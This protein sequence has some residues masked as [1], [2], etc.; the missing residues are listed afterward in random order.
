MLA[1]ATTIKKSPFDPTKVNDPNILE[2]AKKYAKEVHVP[3]IKRDQKLRRDIEKKVRDAEDT[4]VL[5][6]KTEFLLTEE[7]GVLE[8][9]GLERTFKFTQEQ[10]KPNLSISAAAKSFDLKLNTFGPYTMDYNRSGRHL[11][12]GGRKGHVASFDWR[13]GKLGCELHLKET[14]RAVKFLH[15][16]TMFAVAQ[17]K[18]VYIYDN[19]GREIH[20]LKNHRE[21]SNLEYLPYHYLLSSISDLGIVRYLDVSTGKM[22][23]D[24]RSTLGKASCLTQN[25]QNAVI[26]SGHACGTVALWS[27]NSKEPLVKM[28]CHMGP[29][30]GVTID[31]TGMYMATAGMDGKLK[32][33]D[34]RGY[35]PLDEYTTPR[36]AASITFSQRGIL[37]VAFTGNIS[38]WKDVCKEKQNSPYMNHKANPNQIHD[39][40][41]CP[42]EDVLGFGHSGGYSSIVVPGAGEPNFDSLEVNLYQTTKQRREREVHS[43]L[44]KVQP[45][46][47]TLDSNIFGTIAK[48][49]DFPEEQTATTESKIEIR[50]RAR[51]KSSSANRFHRK[52]G[53]QD[54]DRKKERAQKLSDKQATRP[55]SKNSLQPP[56]TV[57][58]KPFSALD[59]FRKKARVD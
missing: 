53:L 33:W 10:L 8:A 23:A 52:K 45:D 9:E 50:N 44:N 21:V 27:P 31:Q 51:G 41:F 59:R 38:L 19:A 34:L 11:L 58:I 3:K 6:A 5:A 1:L 37:A 7:A 17:K 29:V 46:T 36:P 16:E 43:L 15:N 32:V 2:K 55:K 56:Q 57:A 40:Q 30:R 26:H 14:V 49:E 25:I 54:L 20:C 13:A 39:L 48:P 35:K 28:L 42:Y 24:N 4:A 22:V 12:I 47:I 18:Y